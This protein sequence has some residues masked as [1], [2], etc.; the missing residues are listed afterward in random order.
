MF[1][2]IRE[3]IAAQMLRIQQTAKAIASLDA[4]VSLALVAERNNFV[5]PSINTEGV[6]D[7][8]GGRHP[9]VEDSLEKLH[10]DF[11]RLHI[12]RMSMKPSLWSYAGKKSA[13]LSF[14]PDWKLYV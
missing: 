2:E 12:E 7:I 11:P 13:L 4:M 10:T 9:V 3:K 8:K 5:R 14:E 1:V 6:L